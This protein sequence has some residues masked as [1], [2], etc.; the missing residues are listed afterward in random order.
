M[1]TVRELPEVEQ[2]SAAG[3]TVSPNGQ[4]GA[5]RERWIMAAA[6]VAP[7]AAALLLIP[8][9]GHLDTADNALI[10]VVVIV[11]VASTGRRLAAALSALVSA[12]AF[13]FF[14]TRPY[15][16]L[17]IT[18]TS[19]LI[20]EILLLVV[21][22]AVGELAARGRGHRRAA[23]KGREQVAR[24]HSVTEM[25]ATGRDPMEIAAAACRELEQL[26]SLRDCRFT[27]RPDS[28][29]KGQIQPDG[30]VAV[31]AILWAT[32]DL[33]LPTHGV[34]LPVRGHGQVVGHFIAMPIAGVPIPHE[35]LLVAV[36]IADQVGS[37][38]VAN[39][40]QPNA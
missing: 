12:L 15:Y 1:G 32:A 22:L 11:A 27:T 17:R 21:G 34:D 36:A 29:I 40:A 39:A 25:A 16:S 35:T 2:P 14:L 4:S 28:G 30:S 31:G 8:W 33:G 6:V 9:R 5:N 7:I 26:L 37:A 24:L 19:D 18:R 13:D 38:L 23:T 20:T 10:L 3:S